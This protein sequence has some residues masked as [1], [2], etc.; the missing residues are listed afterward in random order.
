MQ[1]GAPLPQVAETRISC[2]FVFALLNA[3]RS[4]AARIAMIAIT[5]SNSMNVNPACASRRLRNSFFRPDILFHSVQFNL[6]P[7]PAHEP[8][9]T[10]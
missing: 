1:G 8:L 4:I 2:A 10:L 3:G 7:L 9:A 6:A 5:T